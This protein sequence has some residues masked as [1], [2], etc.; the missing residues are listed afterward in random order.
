MVSRQTGSVE[1]FHNEFESLSMS[2]SEALE[3]VL[4]SAFINK[5]KIEVRVEV[6]LFRL[7]TLKEVMLRA[8]EIIEKNAVIDSDQTH[9]THQ[10][11]R[12]QYPT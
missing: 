9:Y 2:L 8:Q 10:N 11:Q 7:K 4:M 12:I 1:D 6:K 3:E 5:L